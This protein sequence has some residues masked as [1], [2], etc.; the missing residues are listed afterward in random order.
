MMMQNHVP[1]FNIM[2]LVD[3]SNVINL[4]KWVSIDEKP[5]ETDIITGIMIFEH[6]KNA[7]TLLRRGCFRRR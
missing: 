1:K 7:K 6:N 3:S 4:E 2:P 5:F